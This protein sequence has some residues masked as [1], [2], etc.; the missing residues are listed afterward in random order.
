MTLRYTHY[1]TTN[2]TAIT[3]HYLH[4]TTTTTPLHYN[5]NY[6][7]TTPHYFQQL[8]VRWPTRWPLQRLQ[9]L[10]KT[11]L[12]PP[13]GPSVDSLCHPWFTTTNLSYRF[14]ILEP[15][16]TALCGT[17]G[18]LLCIILCYIILYII[19]LY[20]ILSKYIKL[21]FILLKYILLLY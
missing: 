16:A 10:Q 17:T 1:T 2:A 7:C 11:R 19:I 13:L 12:Q 14:P 4:Y 8:W 3:L 5:H 20:C 18:I 9:P 21:Y 6:S 15:S